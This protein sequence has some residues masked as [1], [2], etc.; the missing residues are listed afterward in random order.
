MV[1]L[2]CPTADATSL[3]ISYGVMNT[4]VTAEVI[5]VSMLRGA[6]QSREKKRDIIFPARD[7][8]FDIALFNAAPSLSVNLAFF[9]AVKENVTS[10]IPRI[11]NTFI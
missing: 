6:D 11:D 1:P 10:D 8:R 2:A 7:P 5:G 4:D 3:T 9:R